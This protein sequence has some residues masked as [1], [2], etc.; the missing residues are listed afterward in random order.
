MSLIYWSIFPCIC[1]KSI[2]HSV[3]KHPLVAITSFKCNSTIMIYFSILEYPVILK[4]AFVWIFA[5]SF[6]FSI[7]KISLITYLIPPFLF[8]YS[9]RYIFIPIA[10]I[11]ILFVMI[12]KF[13]LSKS[14]PIT[15]LPLIIYSI[16]IN[17]PSF[18]VRGTLIKN[19]LV[20][21]AI[22]KVHNTFSMRHTLFPFSNIYC[23]LLI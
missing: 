3:S 22:R 6:F 15:D 13:S 4:I 21:R 7:I 10:L 20:D 1:S 17:E 19:S 18:L 8:A 23:S 11:G 2:H 14:L 16:I 5:T 9:H 12:H